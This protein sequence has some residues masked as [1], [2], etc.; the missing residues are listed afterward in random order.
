MY[1]R[2]L[3]TVRSTAF[4]RRL[5]IIILSVIALPPPPPPPPMTRV[6]I[7][8]YN[9]LFTS[10]VCAPTVIHYF[11]EHSAPS[12]VRPAARTT[13]SLQCFSSRVYVL[14]M[15]FASLFSVSE[16]PS[17]RTEI[18]PLKAGRPGSVLAEIRSSLFNCRLSVYD[19]YRTWSVDD[20]FD[21][22]CAPIISSVHTNFN[23]TYYVSIEFNRTILLFRRETLKKKN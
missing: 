14:Y 9:I 16:P 4:A 22:A 20:V 13:T 21:A 17:L 18:V 23:I 19:N 10:P 5:Y 15:F 3:V 6:T 12:A 1:V 7:I 2:R 8:F 11:L